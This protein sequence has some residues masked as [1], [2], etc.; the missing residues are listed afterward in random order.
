MGKR[1][2]VKVIERV[3]ITDAGAEGKAVGKCVDKVVFVPFAVPGDVIDIRII[4]DR[5]SYMEGRIVKF[6]AYSQYRTDPVCEH[7]GICGGCKWQNMLYEKQLEFKEKLVRD[8]MQ[9]IG[10][11]H[12][13]EP[14]KIIPADQVFHYRSKMEYTFLKRIWLTKEEISDEVE[15]PGGV[16]LH[17]PGRFDK[18]LDVRKCHLQSEPSN[19]IRNA[20]REYALEHNLSFYDNK[21]HEGFLRNVIIRNTG[22]GQWMVIMVFGY[23]N[24]KKIA[25]VMDF[26]NQKFPGLDSLLYVINEKKNDIITDL[27][28]RLFRGEPFI[29]E[30]MDGLKFRIGPLSFFQTNYGQALMLY[31]IARK[32][33]GLA[34]SETVYDLYTGT[35]TIANYLAQ[36]CRHVVGIDNVSQAIGDARENSRINGIENT[37]FFAGEIEKIL[38]RDFTDKNGIPEVLV[39]DPPRPG[40]HEKVIQQ[41]LRVTPSRIVYVSCNP[42]TQARDLKMLAEKY[43]VEAL[44]PVDM[45]PHTQ[46][47]ENV[48][49]LKLI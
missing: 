26:L 28:V 46:H 21:K 6:H 11:V 40:M 12:T 25:A 14:L 34:G 24:D 18:I 47:V 17:I 4:R 1:K 13:P 48:A 49:L 27:K 33:A 38:D 43:R 39:A 42:A 41:I 32:F 9:R 22:S 8:N 19:A 3:E 37:D 2:P 10:G 35:G 5:R 44:Q 36:H 20:L 29:T 7:F 45:F 23:E 16:G 15:K 30:E 31:R